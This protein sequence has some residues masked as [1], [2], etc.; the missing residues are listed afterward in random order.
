LPDRAP[1]E[2][3]VYHQQRHGGGAQG[4]IEGGK[5]HLVGSIK[6]QMQRWF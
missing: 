6:M 3:G 2:E 1:G 5:C 4:K